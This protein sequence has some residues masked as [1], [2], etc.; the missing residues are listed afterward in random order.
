MLIKAEKI[1]TFSAGTKN[2]LCVFKRKA[3]A[4]DYRGGGFLVY[5]KGWFSNKNRIEAKWGSHGGTE[6]IDEVKIW[7]ATGKVGEILYEGSID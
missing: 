7:V 4:P 2:G 1:E 3:P 6:E 5:N